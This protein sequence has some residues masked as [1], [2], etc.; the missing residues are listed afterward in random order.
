MASKTAEAEKKGQ[1][2]DISGLASA[3]SSLRHAINR[4]DWATGFDFDVE[5]GTLRRHN[6]CDSGDTT[7]ALRLIRAACKEVLSNRQE[8]I[9]AVAR[10]LA[11][12]ELA[13]AGVP[14]EEASA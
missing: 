9:I 12:A 6:A 8:H 7:L 11:V 14:D 3:I 5:T 2:R 1:V 13:S 4:L 10:T